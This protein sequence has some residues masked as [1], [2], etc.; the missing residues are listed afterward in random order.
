MIFH[1]VAAEGGITAAAK[2][3]GV[4]K[5]TVS[6]ALARL[7]DELHLKLIQRSTR[8]LRLTEAGLKLFEHC[9]RMKLELQSAQLSMEAFQQTV[10]GT[11]RVTA[12]TASGHA[13]LPGLITS[14]RQQ[15]P[16]IDFDVTLTDAEIDL[17]AS[18]VD[19]AFRTGE[20]RDSNLIARSLMHFDLKLYASSALLRDASVPEQPQ[21]LARFDCL[22]HPAIPIWKLQ[23]G[24]EQFS[25]TPPKNITAENFTFLRELAVRGTS[26]AALPSYLAE[27]DV[28]AGRLISILP[29]WSLERMPFA[30]VYPSKQQ[31]SQAI[32]SF[33]EFTIRY[34]A[35]R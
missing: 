7:E 14:F 32:S 4:S 30:L 18:G 22:Y 8:R 31:A 1:S 20:Q 27:E 26:I 24:R 25:I 6:T 5:S 33:I 28:A 34:F 17:I 12:P 35:A 9:E 23:R 10:T 16:G 19:L 3:L 15:H 21:D 29:E 2:S 13:F 11:V